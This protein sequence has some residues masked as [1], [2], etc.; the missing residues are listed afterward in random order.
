LGHVW[1]HQG[2]GET[3]LALRD[4][5]GATAHFADALTV[6]RD[7]GN[8]EALA[9]CLAGPA[10]AAALDEEPERAAWLWGAA[11]ALR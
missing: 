8:R 7:R 2:L 5:R 3:A 9:W 4:A 11:E 1:A 10:G 6:A